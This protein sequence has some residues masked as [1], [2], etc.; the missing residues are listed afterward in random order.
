MRSLMLA[1]A[2][3]LPVAAREIHPITQTQPLTPNRYFLLRADGQPFKS[4]KGQ[5]LPSIQ[6]GPFTSRLVPLLIRRGPQRLS[7]G[8]T[9]MPV[10]RNHHL[11]AD[12]QVATLEVDGNPLPFPSSYDSF[13][14]RSEDGRTEHI[15]LVL[16]P[17]AR[18]RLAQAQSIAIKIRL[19]SAAFATI[20]ECTNAPTGSARQRAC[21]TPYTGL[22]FTDGKLQGLV[23]S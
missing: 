14:Y 17:S 6:A 9:L 16:Q 21:A 12:R 20:G 10:D 13:T 15:E 3:G 11:S 2:L 22:I 5:P 19:D 4:L 18:T 8:I 1:L 7:L 23:K